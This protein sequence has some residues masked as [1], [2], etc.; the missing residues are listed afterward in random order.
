MCI[1]VER[2]GSDHGRRESSH[3]AVRECR[4]G[5]SVCILRVSVRMRGRDLTRWDV[6]RSHGD[7]DVCIRGNG[8]SVWQWLTL[9]EWDARQRRCTLE[10]RDRLV[11]IWMLDALRRGHAVFR[12]V[13]EQIRDTVDERL[14]NSFVEE[15]SKVGWFALGVSGLILLFQRLQRRDTERKKS[16]R[17][18][19]GNENPTFF[20]NLIP[21]FQLPPPMGL[22]LS[23]TPYS[24]LGSP[25]VSQIL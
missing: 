6:A 2:V 13:P 23:S 12:I 24:A 16:P 7:S 21:V 18:T 25:R 11:E 9:R 10:M 8:S 14:R 15:R 3:I 19:F 4:A 20:A 1:V 22:F 17:F 5:S